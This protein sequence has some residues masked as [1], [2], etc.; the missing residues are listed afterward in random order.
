MG[1]K[2]I[3]DLAVRIGADTSDLT[4]GLQKTEDSMERLAKVGKYAGGIV[5]TSIVAAG[6][7]LTALAVKGVA[8]G[9][10]MAHTAAKLGITVNELS[11][12][13]HA[14]RLLNI[15]A[16]TLEAGMGKLAISVSKAAD[17]SKEQAAALG[18][19]GL[20]A[21]E[22]QGLSITEQMLQTGDALSH[23]TLQ[24]D[25]L[26]IAT[27]LYGRSAGP[28]LVAAFAD[29]AD[30]VRGFMAE[31]EKL[32]L[33]LDSTQ[34]RVI[35]EAA[36]AQDRLAS[37]Y[38]GLALQ[39]GAAFAPA[40][41][42][43]ANAIVTVTTAFT[44]AIPTL[45]SYFEWLTGIQT[46][47]DKLADAALKQRLTDTF[48]ELQG[49]DE[50]LA[51][52][53]KSGMTPEQLAMDG[54]YQTFLHQR[55]EL[56]KRQNELLQE[57][58]KRKKEAAAPPKK[59]AEAEQEKLGL[60]DLD[61]IKG[62]RIQGMVSFEQEMGKVRRQIQMD[63]LEKGVQVDA[64]HIEVIQSFHDIEL[65]MA[66]QHEGLLTQAHRDGVDARIA[67]TKMESGQKIATVLQSMEQIT[68]GVAQYDKKA[69]QVNK[70][71][72]VANAIVNTAQ[73]ATKALAQGGFAG[74][75]MAAAVI[76]AGA[77]QIGAI[78]RTQFEGGGGGTTPSAAGSTPVVNGN[79]VQGSGSG[80]PRRLV[81][82]GL[83]A[84]TLLGGAGIRELAEKLLQF[85]KDG[86]EVV[87]KP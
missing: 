79:P 23:V 3:A 26:R 54:N 81:V 44:E 14:A 40:M 75:A 34:T 55:N 45:Q 35:Q 51:D 15:E 47:A 67:F 63:E 2:V 58:V 20:S 21:K 59:D 17:G 46:A 7:A 70:L 33:F 18:E 1:G 31:A 80:T 16:G 13:R 86:G 52:I 83:N 4:R 39:L 38:D 73:G 74:I 78:K 37:A 84:A 30:A 19:L 24:T 72:A 50:K 27:T 68:A 64:A 76:A 8:L 85:Q 56:L 9:D 82:E 71:A 12:A 49:I 77:A 57:S 48:T 22:L 11:A 87:F 62:K 66:R 61:E 69:F 53:A 5:V 60:I 41:T 32:G 6:A 65:D 25:K 42:A 29:G 10:E 43:A 28:E 36:D